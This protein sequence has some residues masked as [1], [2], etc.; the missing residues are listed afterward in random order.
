MCLLRDLVISIQGYPSDPQ[1][2]SMDPHGRGRQLTCQELLVLMD[3]V[4]RAD[5][6]AEKIRFKLASRIMDNITVE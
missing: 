2:E 1:G 3:T 5:R 4:A 6:A